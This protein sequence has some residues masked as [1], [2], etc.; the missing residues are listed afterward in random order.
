MLP[1][2]T[3]GSKLSAPT[4]ERLKKA[5]CVKLP[6]YFLCNNGTETWSG[7]WYYVVE[8]AEYERTGQLKGYSW[9]ERQEQPNKELI[10]QQ[11][12]I[13]TD[14]PKPPLESSRKSHIQWLWVFCCIIVFCGVVVCNIFNYEPTKKDPPPVNASRRDLSNGGL[15]SFVAIS[16]CWKLMFYAYLGRA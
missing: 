2:R 6:N 1:T 10:S 16:V 4:R 15:R 9:I 5:G 13:A 8:G 7:I 14:I 11:T 12:E 3:H